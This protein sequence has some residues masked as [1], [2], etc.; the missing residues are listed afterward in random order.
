MEVRTSPLAHRFRLDR[1]GY[2]LLDG[3]SAVRLERQPME[4]LI[5][6]A[7]R[8]GQ[9]V[10]RDEI[11]ARLWA[12]GVFVD[13]DRNINSI[14]RKLRLSLKYD[15]D[16]PQ[17]VETVVGKGYRFIGPLEVTPRRM[18]SKLHLVA[19][20]E[21]RPAI[22]DRPRRRWEYAVGILVV[23]GLLG[24]L[25]YLFAA[26][27][28]AQ[29]VRLRQLQQLTVVPLTALPGNVASPTFSPDGIQ[30]AFAWDGENN[31]AGYDLYVKAIG[32]EK[33]LRLTP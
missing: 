14:V 3:N 22:T 12:D 24:G 4:L 8:R 7:E 27:K 6:L 31:G 16:H 23:C 1:D 20:P 15:P 11:A 28:V 26:P 25:L 19:E 18:D 2:Q 10:T 33:P 32:T 9:L 30:I 5:L 13:T 17:F 21:A 29:L